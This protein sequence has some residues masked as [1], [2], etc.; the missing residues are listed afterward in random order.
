MRISSAQRTYLTLGNVMMLIGKKIVA[1]RTGIGLFLISLGLG[2]VLGNAGCVYLGEDESEPAAVSGQVVDESGT[3]LPGVRVTWAGQEA[4]DLSNDQG[5]WQIQALSTRAASDSPATGYLEGFERTVS[6]IEQLDPDGAKLIL[7]QQGSGHPGFIQVDAPGAQTQLRLLE[8]CEDPKALVTGRLG[9]PF[10]VVLAVDVSESMSQALPTG[11]LPIDLV[12][13]AL[14]GLIGEFDFEQTTVAV[15]RFYGSAD[16]VSPLTSDPIEALAA[17]SNLEP[18][19]MGTTNFELVMRQAAQLLDTTGRSGSQKAIVLISDGVPTAH[20]FPTTELGQDVIGQDQ[21]DIDAALSAAFN[22]SSRQIAVHAV[23][24]GED[25]ATSKLTTLPAIADITGGLYL[26][27]PNFNGLDELVELLS[28]Q[29]ID[30]FEVIDENGNAYAIDVAA[31]GTFEAMIPANEG[32]NTFSFAAYTGKNPPVQFASL[33]RTF[34][35]MLQQGEPSGILCGDGKCKSAIFT[36]YLEYHGIVSAQADVFRGAQ[37]TLIDGKLMTGVDPFFL[38]DSQQ[39]DT[40][41]VPYLTFKVD[42]DLDDLYDTEDT[43]RTT[44]SEPVYVG[45]ALGD[46]E[47]LGFAHGRSGKFIEGVLP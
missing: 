9:G 33:Q 25:A 5:F 12:V 14:T 21:Q 36:L 1:Y 47:I 19:E 16:L 15:M 13:Q 28:L 2:L 41:L 17:I 27:L 42:T 8:Q 31:D 10:D 43:I 18:H 38:I 34:Q 11:E 4:D 44:C 26:A 3:P 37:Q 30:D 39:G 29:E 45:M 24:I 46:F 20:G 6:M 23:A 22:L 35:V 40:P 7:Q 32:D